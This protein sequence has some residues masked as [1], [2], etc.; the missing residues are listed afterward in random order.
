MR[1]RR[2]GGFAEDSTRKAGAV[3][4]YD[5]APDLP[6]LCVHLNASHQVVLSWPAWASS[7]VLES[8]NQVP[9]TSPWPAVTNVPSASGNW[10]YVTNNV[11]SDNRFYRLHRP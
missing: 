1:G 2:L 6:A 9:A 7:F 8:T 10:F 3:I 11:G 5:Q 4:E